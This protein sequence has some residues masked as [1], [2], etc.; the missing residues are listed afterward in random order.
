M[1]A[2]K[3]PA[4]VIVAILMGSTPSS[5]WNAPPPKAQTVQ[6]CQPAISLLGSSGAAGI[7]LISANR[8]SP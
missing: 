1:R 3:I 2:A 4:A 6:V 7:V 5:S 8:C